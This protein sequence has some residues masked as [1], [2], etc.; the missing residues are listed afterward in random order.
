MYTFANGKLYII[1]I[2]RLLCIAA[3]PKKLVLT[4][5]HPV[6]QIGAIKKARTPFVFDTSHI[7]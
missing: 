6:V 2:M 3:R 7:L 1:Y 4:D 5:V